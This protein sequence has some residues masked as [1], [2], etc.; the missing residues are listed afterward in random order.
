MKHTPTPWGLKNAYPGTSLNYYQILDADGDGVLGQDSVTTDEFS[1]LEATA[2]RIVECVNAMD[3]IADPMTFREQYNES[4][5]G[6]L[7]LT[8]EELQKLGEQY[9]NQ[10]ETPYIETTTGEKVHQKH[11][12]AASKYIGLTVKRE[13]Q[14]QPKDAPTKADIEE[15]MNYIVKYERLKAAVDHFVFIIENGRNIT[16]HK[17]SVILSL[18]K[19]EIK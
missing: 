4:K 8:Q 16:V 10:E 15:L 12:G 19:D 7:I 11:T 1:I 2:K 3:G 14:N 5:R 17:Y 13:E 6:K 18:L 9:K